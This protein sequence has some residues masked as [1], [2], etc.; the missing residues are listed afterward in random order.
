MCHV[1]KTA[2]EGADENY[3]SGPSSG[4]LEDLGRCAIRTQPSSLTITRDFRIV[5]C[6]E[7]AVSE[8]ASS[9]HDL[10]EH[11][12]GSAK[13]RLILWR[14][15]MWE[16]LRVPDVC[17]PKL[18]VSAVS[19]LPQEDLLRGSTLESVSVVEHVGE[20]TDT[21]SLAPA[22]V[23]VCCCFAAAIPPLTSRL[24]N[25]DFVSVISWITSGTTW[26]T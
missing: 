3:S 19:K 17:G 4:Q 22:S 11:H 6:I 16:I 10:R 23:M 26:L 24:S 8:Q 15:E 14:A 18:A 2:T 25:V 21:E 20:S 7:S 13:E 5:R 1:L 12:P 9:V